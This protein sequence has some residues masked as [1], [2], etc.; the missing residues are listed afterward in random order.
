VIEELRELSRGIHPAILREGGLDAAIR[1]LARRSAVPVALDI[2][3][4]GRASE[5]VEV[6]VFYVVSEALTNAAKHAQA[7]CVH[8]TVETRDDMLEVGICDD[9]VGGARAG[10]GSGLTGLSDRVE[11][12][13]G[14]MTLTSP[15]GEG[16]SLRVSFQRGAETVDGEGDEQS[17]RDP[18]RR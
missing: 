3:L 5:P 18:R 4:E 1:G 7:S 9:G 17:E 8:V 10:P 15:P 16:T 12:I 11:A 13:G 14:T 2:A 6:A